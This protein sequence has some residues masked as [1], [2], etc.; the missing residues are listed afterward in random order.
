MGE[1]TGRSRLPE[2]EGPRH[3]PAPYKNGA[4]RALIS[5]RCARVRHRGKRSSLPHE[6]LREPHG[7]PVHVFSYFVACR[8]ACGRAPPPQE[9]VARGLAP[10]AFLLSAGGAARYKSNS[11]LDAYVR[12]WAAGGTSRRCG[13]VGS[14]GDCSWMSGF[15]PIDVACTIHIDRVGLLDDERGPALTLKF[16]DGEELSIS[17]ENAH[18]IDRFIARP[19]LCEYVPKH[20]PVQATDAGLVM[21][22][23]SPSYLL[24]LWP[25]FLNKLLYATDAGLRTF[26][27]IGELPEGLEK[28]SSQA[29]FDSVQVTQHHRRLRSF[30]DSRHGGDAP[31]GQNGGRKMDETASNHYVKMPSALA[32]LAAPGIEGVYYVD[33]DAVTSSAHTD[34]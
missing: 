1:I 8:R 29:C 26:L 11:D 6:D 13:D 31:R 33:L 18:N 27:W 19:A 25:P 32:A 28:P 3:V 34:P 30:Y 4:A 17:T 7:A 24:R 12:S 16:H 10:L 9:V 2:G 14:H 23:N 21:V 5:K 15:G 20:R 22:S